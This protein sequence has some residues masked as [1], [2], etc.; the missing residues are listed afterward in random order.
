MILS[1]QNFIRHANAIF[2]QNYLLDGRITSGLRFDF[3]PKDLDIVYCKTDYIKLL[4]DYLGNSKFKNIALMTHESDY[5]IT[6]DLFNQRPD[7]IKI[8]YGQNIDH[9]HPDLKPL[10]IG[11]AD[12]HCNITLKFDRLYRI[13]Q[14]EKLLYIN[15]R[16]QNNPKERSWIYDYFKSSDWCTVQQPN[17][18]LD[19]YREDLDGHEFILCPK[20]NGID[21]HRCWE[22]LYHGIIP[23]VEEHVSLT[24]VK[25]LPALVVPNFKVLDK[26]YLTN[27]LA[28]LKNQ[29]FNMNKLQVQYWINCIKQDLNSRI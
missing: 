24:T 6:A 29:S 3:K 13:K 25:D 11:L 22:A 18:S 23:I 28:A 10:P 19:S 9:I 2:A 12:A 8:W 16:I 15:H 27:A 1:G 4:F 5:A 14:P 26:A 17:L 20:G 7:C 21:T